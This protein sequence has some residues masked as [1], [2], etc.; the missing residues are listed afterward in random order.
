MLDQGSGH[1]GMLR[2]QG[3]DWYES[4]RARGLMDEEAL[5]GAAGGALSARPHATAIYALG[6]DLEESA[7]LRQQSQEIGLT[8]PGCSTGSVPRVS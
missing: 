8:V 1:P 6:R 5:A 2:R 7:R 4:A 3:P